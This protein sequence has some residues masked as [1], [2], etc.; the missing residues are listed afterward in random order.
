MSLVRGGSVGAY[1][2]NQ[3]SRIN[4]KSLWK[5]GSSL[6]K[7]LK[8]AVENRNKR[9]KQSAERR[10]KP[11]AKASV[12]KQIEVAG[13]ESRSSFYKSKKGGTTYGKLGTKTAPQF[14]VLNEGIRSDAAI[15]QQNSTLLGTYFDSSDINSLYAVVFGASPNATTDLYLKGV[16][17]E[18][19]ITNV[20][21]TNARITI[22]DLCLRNDSALDPSSVFE[23]SFSDSAGGANND[24]NIPGTTPFMNVQFTQYFKICQTT[25]IIL[26]PGATHSHLVNYQPN[27]K[28]NKTRTKIANGGIGD[29]TMFTMILHHGSPANDSATK[30][31]VSLS[32]SSLDIVTK[33]LYTFFS[34]YYPLT[35]M[36]ATQ[37]LPT[38]FAVAGQNINEDGVVQTTTE[39]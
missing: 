1:Q 27:Q 9:Q 32:K 34:I 12:G 31:S 28:I 3:F 4:P 26:S 2:P 24:F 21:S 39:A 6:G 10:S 29:L 38:A 17:A 8:K 20:A 19:L 13:G 35:S 11:A 7:E 14:R 16:R 30:T 18:S 5:V 36:L 22:Y 37:S 25:D 33:Q 23:A 15:G